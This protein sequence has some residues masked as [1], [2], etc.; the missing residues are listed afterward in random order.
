MA[1]T[2]VAP[3]GI[4]S[5]PGTG[6]VI[7]DSFLHATGLNAT[8]AYYTGI[9]TAQTFRVIGDFQV[10][11]TT[12][13]LDTVVTEVDKLEVGA[14][15]N[16]VGLAV[17]QSGAG[18]VATFEGGN[19][20]IGTA[21]PSSALEIRTTT[22]NAATH[23]RN[24]A[25]NGGA[26]FG[27]RATELGAAGAGEAYVYS[28]N[29]GINLLADGNGDINFA[30]GG[31]ASR[32]RISSG[33]YVGINEANPTQQLHVHDDTNYQGI[34]IN[35]SSA[36]RLTFA[37]SGSTT[38]EWGVGIDGTNGNNFAIAQAGNTAKFIID[39]NGKIGIGDNTPDNT[40]SIKGL[41]SFDA[42]SNSF[43]FG[44]NFTGTGQNYIGS[45]KHAQ[46]FFLNN[47]SANGYFSYS[48]TGSA[49][50]AGNAITWQERF[51]ITS[52]G[53]VGI[54]QSSPAHQLDVKISDNTTYTPGNFILNGAARLHN[55]ST[56]TNSF[57]S[58][59]FRTA[60]GDNAIGFIY[61]GSV[62]QADFVICNDGGANGVERLRITADGDLYLNRTSQLIDAKISI[63]ADAGE[64][65]IAGQMS[66]NSGTSTVLQTYNNSGNISSNISVDNANRSLI[67]KGANTEGIRITSSG[68]VGIG[69]DNPTGVLDINST[70][71]SY[72]H[73]RLRRT[74]SGVG[75]SDWSLKPYAGSLYFRT[76]GANDKIVFTSG[77]DVGIGEFSP[78]QRLDVVGLAHTVALFRPDNAS[79]SAYGNASVVNNLINLRMPY[80]L[81]PGGANNN[82]ARWGIKFQG[83]NDGAEYGTDTS[84][85][86]SIYA[87]SEDATA[88]Y[89]R[90]VGLAFYTSGFDA[91]Q[92]E[93]LR[94]TSGGDLG[95]GVSGGMNQAGTLY[96]Q[97]GQGVRWTH[98]LDGTLY[99]DHY[100]SASGHHVF[101]TGSGLTERLRITSAGD[102]NIPGGILNLGTADASSGHINSYELMS[103][104]I[105]TDNDDTNRYFIFRTNAGTNAGTE[106][107][108][109]TEGGNLGIGGQDPGA[110]DGGNSNYNNWD[111]PKLHVRGPSTS[112]K[113]H[114]LGRFHAGNDAD[115]T[116]AQ[117]V[118]HHE[119]DRGMA[120]QG[121]RSSGNRS[122]GAIKSLDNLARESNVMVFTGGTGQG[123]ENIKFYTNGGSTGTNERMSINSYGTVHTGGSTEIDQT[124]LTPD[125]ITQA[126]VV[127]PMFYR[128]FSGM[129]G[130]PSTSGPGYVDFGTGGVRHNL[131]D[132]HLGASYGGA[133]FQGGLIGSYSQTFSNTASGTTREAMN[134]NR[135][136]IL[137]RG[138]CL[139]SGH[140]A[141]TVKFRYSTY[142]YSNGWQDQAATEWSFSGTEQARGARWVVGPWMNPSSVFTGWADVPAFGLY[143]NDNSSG[144][145][146]RIAGGVYFQFAHFI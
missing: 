133:Q 76:A 88:G 5:T 94:I 132:P 112:S 24:N 90:K 18:H 29:S 26:Y 143:Y 3:A 55:E 4:G 123:V 119:N 117:I 120:L 86:A 130:A 145:T 44:S 134:W 61:P 46:R 125:L 126:G 141:S 39:A 131:V 49:G 146:F 1:L 22:T 80:G 36:P 135:I 106:L 127:S 52:D 6:Y 58:L 81:N 97:G 122:Y 136:R 30:T 118:I 105:D 75:D 33:G 21:T 15:N 71:G 56:T 50:T 23:Y 116:G 98:T 67:L 142:H 7:G 110:G 27:V 38:V 48:N 60:T 109:L 59:V 96:I 124:T 99:G 100:V 45:S 51:R 138:L 93:R 87:V 83:R 16:T 77:G 47:A 40:L 108:R 17:T 20:G 53:K 70:S 107:M 102:V 35:G 28:Y 121:G 31:T 73:L 129:S 41:G 79:V 84:K 9:V 89:N 13:T 95:L 82:G 101:R 2:R 128:P 43:Y 14:N 25:S 74:S 42:D 114:L 63:G 34:L 8:N 72:D 78:Q 140:T 68:L 69:T 144:R 62:N 66:T 10:D 92:T 54:N 115:S 57:A 12:T 137:F 65:L 111:T 85:S 113:F 32:V 91:N 104:N 19:V 64:A 139:S 37:K 11:G 103:F